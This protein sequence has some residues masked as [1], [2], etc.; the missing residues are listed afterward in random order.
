MGLPNC[1]FYDPRARV[2][3]VVQTNNEYSNDDRGKIY[4]NCK[5]YDP[6]D[7]VLE[8]V[9]KNMNIVMMTEERPTQI[10]GRV[11]V[12]VCGRI[13]HIVIRQYFL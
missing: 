13:S 1:K 2:L 8:V 4:T 5:S 11:I 3:E 9:Q 7:R 10:R 6:R 12:F